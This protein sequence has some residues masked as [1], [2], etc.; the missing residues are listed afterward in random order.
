[1]AGPAL[2]H[3]LT[4]RPEVWVQ[5]IRAEDIVGEILDSVPAP[6]AEEAPGARR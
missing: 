3:R 6:T 5:Q 1:V 4:L 2:G